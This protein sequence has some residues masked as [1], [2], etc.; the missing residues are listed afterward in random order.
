MGDQQS[1]E[2]VQIQD[3]E[4]GKSSS[5]TGFFINATGGLRRA[6]RFILQKEE[7][8]FF[9]GSAHRTVTW[10]DTVCALPSRSSTIKPT[11]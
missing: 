5:G 9:I 3:P 11:M 10:T 2:G 7:S 8:P 4:V 1:A 6:P